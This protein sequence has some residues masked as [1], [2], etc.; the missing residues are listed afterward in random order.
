MSTTTH[1]TAPRGDREIDPEALMGFIHR[2]VGEV[3][4]SLNAAL[5]VMGDE[6]GYYRELAG[7]EAL[8]PAELAGRTGTDARYAGEWLN[9]QAADR[10]GGAL[11]HGP[12]LGRTHS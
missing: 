3:G 7:G 12:G 5:V 4:A 1:T 9:A 8:T 6:L 2:V 10:R 11:R